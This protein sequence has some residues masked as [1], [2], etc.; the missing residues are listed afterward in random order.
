LI[1]FCSGKTNSNSGSAVLTFEWVIL[2]LRLLFLLL[3]L[4]GRLFNITR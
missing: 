4:V 2:L 3:N 1:K